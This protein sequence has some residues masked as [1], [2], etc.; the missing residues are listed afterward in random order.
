MRDR[1][2]RATRELFLTDDYTLSVT[3]T[4]LERL[5]TMPQDLKNLL[6]LP[7]TPLKPQSWC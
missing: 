1:A 7:R 3:S 6:K 2:P 4:R 5:A